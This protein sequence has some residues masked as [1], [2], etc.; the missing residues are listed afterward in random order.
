M[1]EVDVK[2]DQ[3]Q[4][5]ADDETPASHLL[6]KTLQEPKQEQ[7]IIVYYVKTVI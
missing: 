2:K 5:R 6:Q 3:K 1:K 4:K 7:G